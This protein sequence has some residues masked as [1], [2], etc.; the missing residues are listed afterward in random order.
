MIDERKIN[1]TH[2]SQRVR[3]GYENRL[4][5]SNINVDLYHY[6]IYVGNFSMVFHAWIHSYAYVGF[7][8]GC[9]EI[10]LGFPNQWCWRHLRLPNKIFIGWMRVLMGNGREGVDWI[11]GIFFSDN[12]RWNRH[13]R[14]H[15]CDG[16]R[17]PQHTQAWKIHRKFPTYL[18]RWHKSTFMFDYL[19]RFSYSHPQHHPWLFSLIAVTL[20]RLIE[21]SRWCLCNAVTYN[22]DRNFDEQPVTIVSFREWQDVFFST[23]FL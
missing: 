4:N 8:I 17:V 18:I 16:I 11:N 22:C 13:R 10:R 21:N 3:W 15:N 5:S 14:L 12:R 7:L 23:K 2:Y 19:C 6:N 9:T 1:F 20:Q